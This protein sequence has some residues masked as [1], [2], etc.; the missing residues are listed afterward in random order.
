[1]GSS[2][3]LKSDSPANRSLIP[4]LTLSPGRGPHQAPSLPLTFSTSISAQ[5]HCPL[6][7]LPVQQNP[8]SDPSVSLCHQLSPRP[9]CL[10]HWTDASKS[11]RCPLASR[12]LLFIPNRLL[13]QSI[14][15]PF[16]IFLQNSFLKTHQPQ[17]FGL[18]P[19]RLHPLSGFWNIISHWKESSVT[20]CF[21]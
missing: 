20:N 8:Y 3:Q 9:L 5:V 19:G 6:Q 4:I 2:W 14:W 7:T 11:E 15:V 17:L 12:L 13:S 16:P 18:I 10:H 1:M 21:E